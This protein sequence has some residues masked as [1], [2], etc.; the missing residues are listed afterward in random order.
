MNPH[1]PNAQTSV[2]QNILICSTAFFL[3]SES[4]SLPLGSFK[5]F[6]V[7]PPSQKHFFFY[8]FFLMAGRTFTVQTHNNDI[9]RWLASLVKETVHLLLE[10]GLK[11]L[12]DTFLES[13]K[14]KDNKIFWVLQRC[15]C[16]S[17]ES[18]KKNKQKNVFVLLNSLSKAVISPTSLIVSYN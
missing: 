6:F 2:F 4:L 10:Q 15:R 13:S 17:W 7:L 14:Q 16:S 8:F 9:F 11:L 12:S 5:S 1:I 18:Q 3:T